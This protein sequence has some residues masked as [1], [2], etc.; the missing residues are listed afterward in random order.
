MSCGYVPENPNAMSNMSTAM[1]TPPHLASIP[2]YAG[3][4]GSRPRAY[5]TGDPNLDITMQLQQQGAM[6]DQQV[7]MQAD[8]PLGP[9]FPQFMSV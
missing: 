2:E 4:Y 1:P 8:Q 6:I 5:T 9:A 7:A 3:M